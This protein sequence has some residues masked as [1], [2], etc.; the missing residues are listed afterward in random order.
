LRAEQQYMEARLADL[1]AQEQQQVRVVVPEQAAR[2]IDQVLDEEILQQAEY[3]II[4][5]DDSY[6]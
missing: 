5:L 3:D 2:F 6:P 4:T 1:R